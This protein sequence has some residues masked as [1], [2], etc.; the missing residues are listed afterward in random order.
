MATVLVVDDEV[1]LR[2]LYSILCQGAGW[3][4]VLQA[5]TGKEAY[6]VLSHHPEISLVVTDYSMPEGNGGQLYQW[7]RRDGKDVPFVVISAYDLK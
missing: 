2:D 3:S 4:T 7:S 6:Q 5:G 1:D